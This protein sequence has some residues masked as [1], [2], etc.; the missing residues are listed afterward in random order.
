MPSLCCTV[1]FCHAT[2]S[3]E[4]LHTPPTEESLVYLAFARGNVK[5]THHKN[6]LLP[7]SIC[8]TLP[9]MTKVICLET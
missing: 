2:G 8:N 3:E 4:H 9:S 5:Q 6:K 1:T 7:F